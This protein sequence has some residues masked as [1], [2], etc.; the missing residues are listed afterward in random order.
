MR[1]TCHVSLVTRRVCETVSL[2]FFIQPLL[3]SLGPKRIEITFSHFLQSHSTR[4]LLRRGVRLDLVHHGS[5]PT[6]NS[7]PSHANPTPASSARP[8]E[9]RCGWCLWSNPVSGGERTQQAHTR[10]HAH[11]RAG[12]SVMPH[13]STH[14]ITSSLTDTHLMFLNHHASLHACSPRHA[15]SAAP[16]G[17]PGSA[18][19]RP[20][21]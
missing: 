18:R 7:S 11:T 10:A 2:L 20:C 14:I 19:S 6:F 9:S 15:A 17:A 8:V 13:M 16:G 12:V 21:R 4:L 3:S 5:A 1:S